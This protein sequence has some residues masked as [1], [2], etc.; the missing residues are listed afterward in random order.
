MIKRCSVLAFFIIIVLT[1]QVFASEPSKVYPD[2]LSCRWTWGTY[3]IAYVLKEYDKEAAKPG[4]REWLNKTGYIIGNGY[5]SLPNIGIFI[6][7]AQEAKWVVEFDY[8]K[9]VKGA[10]VYHD[11]DIGLP[12]YSSNINYIREVIG[13]TVTIEWMDKD[14]LIQQQRVLVKNMRQFGANKFR[15]YI[16]PWKVAQ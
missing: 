15:G 3:N 13:E 2:E 9:P 16:Y 6:A 12:T 8:T 1:S 4:C 14:G 5:H 10:I 11:N 7:A